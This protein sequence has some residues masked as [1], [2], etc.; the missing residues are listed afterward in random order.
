MFVKLPNW[1]RLIR[2]SICHRTG[3]EGLKGIFKTGA[4][5]P[6]DGSLADTYPQ[7]KISYARYHNLISLFDFKNCNEDECL[8]Q[9]H[10]WYRFFFDHEPVTVVILLSRQ[11]LE[12][13]LIPNEKAVKDTKGTFD[14]IFIPNLEVFCPEPIPCDVFKGYLVICG[15]YEKI[16]EYYQ[17]D[18]IFPEIF[19]KIDNFLKK[20][21]ALY[22]DPLGQLEKDIEKH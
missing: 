16:Y 22:A 17:H 2:N 10:D 13:K 14:P 3:I 7:S 9:I 4:I 8:N 15:V 6:N 20:H 21:E 19:D 5:I 18:G 1:Y 12:T 11:C